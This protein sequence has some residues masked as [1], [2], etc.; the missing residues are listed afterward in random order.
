M[1]QEIYENHGKRKRPTYQTIRA[2]TWI[3]MPNNE[4][5]KWR[6]KTQSKS[7]SGHRSKLLILD[8]HTKKFK[9]NNP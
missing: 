1:G 6:P 4:P 5:K 9:K 3:K 8:T 2:S 7:I